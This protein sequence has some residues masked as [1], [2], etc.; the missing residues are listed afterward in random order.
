MGMYEILNYSFIS[1]KWL[2]KL[3]LSE[4]DARLN[5]VVIRN[6]LGEDTSV[7]RTSLVPSMLNTVSANLNRGIADGKLFELT[8]TFEPAK[9]AGLAARRRETRCAIGDVRF[10]R[11]LLCR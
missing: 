2:E 7:M 4:N 9:E 6:P 10:R 5:T 8:K 1:P 3:G 11:G